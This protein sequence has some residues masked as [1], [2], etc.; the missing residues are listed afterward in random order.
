MKSLKFNSKNFLLYFGLGLTFFLFL[1][2]LIVELTTPK[3]PLLGFHGIIGREPSAPKSE[4][5]E[6]DYP[7]QE[8]EIFI[9]YLVTQNYWF[10]TTQELY[11]YF[12]TSAKSIPPEHLNQ[13]PIMLSFDDGYKTVYTHL[14]PFLDKIEEKYGKKVKIVL[15][16]NPGTLAKAKSTASTHLK[17]QNLREGLAK[18]FYDIQSHG[19]NH[20]NLTKLTVQELIHE[21]ST[22]Q[23]QLRKCTAGLDSEQKVASHLA[24]P[25]GAYNQRVEYYASKYYLSSYLYNSRILKYSF[26]RNYYEIPRLTV[27]RTKSASRLIKMAERSHLIK[28]S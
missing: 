23:I 19:L 6:M 10:I 13:K 2:W 24:Y 26:L 3:I 8:L 9:E 14:I 7:Q 28:K 27:N 1:T 5:I 11:D 20:K 22:A 16:V 4:L 18:G 12:L 21:L 25:Y 15:F 17:C